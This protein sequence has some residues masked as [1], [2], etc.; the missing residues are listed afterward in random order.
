MI[1]RLRP[2]WRDALALLFAVGD[3]RNPSRARWAAVLALQQY[4][5]PGNVRELQNAIE[6]AAVLSAGR[7]ISVREI[8]AGNGL[9]ADRFAS[10]SGKA[11]TEPLFPDN[12]YLPANRRVTV[13]LLSEAPPTPRG[14]GFP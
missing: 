1:S 11:D 4:D 12:P 7:A 8:L 9:S 6:R 5:F 3:R 14:V 13:T 10:V 2:F